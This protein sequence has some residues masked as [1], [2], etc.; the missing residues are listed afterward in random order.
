MNLGSFH[1]TTIIRGIFINEQSMV[2]L[3]LKQFEIEILEKQ[4]MGFKKISYFFEKNL[5]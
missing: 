5:F 1:S 3:G 2:R 4:L